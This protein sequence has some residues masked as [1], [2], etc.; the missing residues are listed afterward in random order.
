MH[1][2][3]PIRSIIDKIRD[4]QDIDLEQ[5]TALL[6]TDDHEAIDYLRAQAREVA[7]SIYGNA[8]FMRGLIEFSNV[9]RNNCRYCGI[10][11]DNTL[12][13]RYRL[14]DD[15]ILDCCRM[16]YECGLRTF[17]L[18][19]GEDGHYD[20]PHIVPL[21]QRIR[22]E[23]PD[24]AITLSLGERSRESYQKLFDAGANRYLLRHETADADHYAYLHP[25]EM[26]FEH[27]MQCL[28]D[29]RDIG[30]Q[31]GAGFMVGSPGQTYG[32]LLKDLQFIRSFKPEMC[33]I[34]PFIA[35]QNTPFAHE[36]NGSVEQTLRL[37]SIIRLLH[38]HV[39][40]PATTALGT[41]NAFG[42]E[43]GIQAGANVV[44]PNLSPT[45]NRPKYSIYDGKICLGD[46]IS[47]CRSCLETRIESVGYKMV[48]DRGDYIRDA[49]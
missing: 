25:A 5:L 3:V 14:D 44:M 8:V 4:S 20:D 37:L 9:C 1:T 2:T 41:L 12:T 27:R 28:R 48:V 17:V 39:L 49:Q 43:L 47:H 45:E 31:V 36:P 34:G 19:A 13:E 15:T 6:N 23:F 35:A 38:P 26:S 22:A 18:Q 42:R 30:Y 21:V 40:L 7:Q 46:N 33:G 10:R 32:T 24:C 16:G 29:L 11:R